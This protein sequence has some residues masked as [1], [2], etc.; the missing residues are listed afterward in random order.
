MTPL[1]SKVGTQILVLDGVKISDAPCWKDGR[2]CMVLERPALEKVWAILHDLHQAATEWET[3]PHTHERDPRLNPEKGD[4]VRGR[5]GTIRKVLGVWQ[6][7]DGQTFV[8][9]RPRRNGAE[10][11]TRND[12]IEEWRR[13]CSANV[14]ESGSSPSPVGEGRQP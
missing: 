12:R 4:E 2:V 14:L 11:K 10:H 9:Y 8:N 7:S 1:H 6:H 3:Q 5:T 13:W